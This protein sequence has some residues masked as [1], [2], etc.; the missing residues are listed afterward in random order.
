M[1]DTPKYTVCPPG[2]EPTRHTASCPEMVRLLMGG[3]NLTIDQRR[4]GMWQTWE[5]KALVAVPFMGRVQAL[6]QKRAECKQ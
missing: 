6:V 5:G 4:H 1:N 3:Q 2:P